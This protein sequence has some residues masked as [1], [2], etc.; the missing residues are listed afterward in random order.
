MRLH[1]L[2]LSVLL[3][4]CLLLLIPAVAISPAALHKH[5]YAVRRER[6]GERM[7]HD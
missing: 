4:L 2:C 7:H 5:L 3:H 6:E 1:S